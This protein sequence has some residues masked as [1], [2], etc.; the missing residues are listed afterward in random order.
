MTGRHH[1]A[2]LAGSV[3]QHTVRWSS[4]ATIAKCIARLVQVSLS[5]VA[6]TTGLPCGILRQLQRLGANEVLD[7]QLAVSDQVGICRIEG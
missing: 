1:L 3:D 4:Q 2:D 7:H 6:A 5:S